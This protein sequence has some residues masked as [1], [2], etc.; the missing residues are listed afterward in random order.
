M[1]I[2][3]LAMLGASIQ[4][5]LAVTGIEGLGSV[6]VQASYD[7]SIFELTLELTNTSPV[8][9]GGYLTAFAFENPQDWVSNITTF[10]SSNSN[11][12]LM[13][14]T[15][16]MDTIQASPFGDFDIGASAT[17]GQWLGGGNPSG[18]I[19]AGDMDTFSFILA[20]TNLDTVTLEDFGSLA[21][22]MRGFDGG[23]SDKILTPVPE[24][25]T[26][27]MMLVG[28]GVLGLHA[29]RKRSAAT[30]FQA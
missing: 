7:S 11:F 22:R 18:G 16:F 24:L 17:G 27:I 23:G 14:G 26:W 30:A 2:S 15:S 25:S 6:D 10:S 1:L 3:G 13:G 9:N 5:S 8:D 28:L 29:S 19:A 20:G 21:I 12:A 4:P